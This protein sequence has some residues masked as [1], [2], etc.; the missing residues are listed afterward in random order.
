MPAANPEAQLTLFDELG[1]IM[2]IQKY[3]YH[4]HWYALVEC[5]LKPKCSA[6]GYKCNDIWLGWSW[7]LKA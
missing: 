4:H 6:V 3:W 5:F 1:V 2:L 7:K